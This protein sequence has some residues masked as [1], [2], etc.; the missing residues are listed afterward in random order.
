MLTETAGVWRKKKL[1]EV[2][3]MLYLFSLSPS[4]YANVAYIFKFV[5]FNKEKRMKKFKY[6]ILSRTY[7]RTHTFIEKA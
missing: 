5:S 2:N 7:T 4:C 6:L 1:I 3:S